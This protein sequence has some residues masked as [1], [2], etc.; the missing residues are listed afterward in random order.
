MFYKFH[1]FNY[2]FTRKSK[3][4]IKKKERNLKNYVWENQ[5]NLK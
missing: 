5:Q 4:K 3:K 1:T 2:N